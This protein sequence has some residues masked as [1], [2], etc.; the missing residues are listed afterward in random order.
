LFLVFLALINRSILY[1]KNIFNFLIFFNNII[2]LGVFNNKYLKFNQI[3][4]LKSY[5]NNIFGNN[6]FSLLNNN[7]F[8]RLYN[9]INSSKLN[10]HVFF[11]Y[12]K[13]FLNVQTFIFCKLNLLFYTYFYKNRDFLLNYLFFL[14]KSKKVILFYRPSSFI[15]KSCTS[16]KLVYFDLSFLIKSYHLPLFFNLYFFLRRYFY[17]K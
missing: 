15:F 16:L 3:T 2:M 1:Y 7:S 10:S 11:D 12:S 5:N 6:N 14:K 8:L 4:Y 9:I 17:L 13:K